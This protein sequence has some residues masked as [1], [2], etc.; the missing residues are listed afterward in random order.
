MLPRHDG[1]GFTTLTDSE[2]LEVPVYNLAKTPLVADGYYVIGVW[3][4]RREESSLEMGAT[5]QTFGLLT[6]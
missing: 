6:F 2:N 5:W 1:P 4:P 3:L